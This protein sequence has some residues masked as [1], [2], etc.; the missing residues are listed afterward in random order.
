MSR[1]SE[2]LET[3]GLAQYADAF[4]ANDMD[5]DL[6]GQL[7][8]CSGSSASRLSIITASMSFAGSCFDRL[9]AAMGL[10]K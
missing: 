1:V 10:L 3:I 2:W 6:L 8:G 4:H 9:L 7:L 5:I